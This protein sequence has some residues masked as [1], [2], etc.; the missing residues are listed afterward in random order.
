MALDLKV[1]DECVVHEQVAVR[2]KV[3]KVAR[4]YLTVKGGGRS[5]YFDKANRRP[6]GEH[7]GYIPQ[8]RTVTEQETVTAWETMRSA[9]RAL[10]SQPP[11]GVSVESIRRVTAAALALTESK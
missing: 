1:G 9:L 8:L 4:V 3:T 2:C 5:W 10:P 11:H 6:R 7:C